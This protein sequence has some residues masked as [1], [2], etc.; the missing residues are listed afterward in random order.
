M[1]HNRSHMNPT[2]ILMRKKVIVK[3]HKKLNN[4]ESRSSVIKQ[5]NLVNKRIFFKKIKSICTEKIINNI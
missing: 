5:S 3:C 2:K 4:F 1:L